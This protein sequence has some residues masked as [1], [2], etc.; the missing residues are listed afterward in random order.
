MRMAGAVIVTSFL[1][2]LIIKGVTGL[3]QRP[4]PADAENV[5]GA[6]AVYT[7]F[8]SRGVFLAAFAWLMVALALEGRLKAR[9]VRV[10]VY[11]LAAAAIVVVCVSQ[12]WLGLHWVTDV[13][14]GL[15]GGVGLGLLGRWVIQTRGIRRT[16]SRGLE[17]WDKPQA[18][19]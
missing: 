14:A 15:T 3:A 12:L 1:G 6:G 18:A 4:R 2:Y 13:L 9:S 7:S 8:P 11:A 16:S 10:G 5:L 19:G 17:S